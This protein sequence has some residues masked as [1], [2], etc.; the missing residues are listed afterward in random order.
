CG[1]RVSVARTAASQILM[2][3]AAGRNPR[4]SLGSLTRSTCAGARVAGYSVAST[5]GTAVGARGRCSPGRRRFTPRLDR[6]RE[7]DPKRVAS[8]EL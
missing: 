4:R 7:G 6:G 3:L 8:G 2:A 5:V 1:G